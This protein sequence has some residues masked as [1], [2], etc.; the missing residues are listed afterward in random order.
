MCAHRRAVLTTAGSYVV[1]VTIG[2]KTVPG[3]PKMVHILPGPANAASSWLT[4]DAIKVG[5][6]A[7]AGGLHLAVYV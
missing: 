7:T 2:G 4:G 1:T 6:Q 5:G 3:W